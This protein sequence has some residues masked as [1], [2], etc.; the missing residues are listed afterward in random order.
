MLGHANSQITTDVYTQPVASEARF[1]HDNL[2]DMI[3]AVKRP[4]K[5]DFALVA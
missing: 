5:S 3:I 4:A 1:A 2:V